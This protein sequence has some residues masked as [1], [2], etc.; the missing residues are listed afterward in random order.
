LLAAGLTSAIPMALTPLDVPVADRRGGSTPGP[1]PH[2]LCRPLDSHLNPSRRGAAPLARDNGDI[3]GD[4]RESPRPATVLPSAFA[5]L[6]QRIAPRRYRR[7]RRP[8]RALLPYRI[9]H[10]SL[11][12]TRCLSVSFTQNCSSTAVTQFSSPTRGHSLSVRRFVMTTAQFQ[13]MAARR[14][15][16]GHD[17]GESATSGVALRRGVDCWGR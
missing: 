16:M 17:Y 13:M 2:G 5:R 4:F 9:Q 14:S 11:W 7:C 15:D 8:G 1:S 3:M 10:T 6:D 12:F